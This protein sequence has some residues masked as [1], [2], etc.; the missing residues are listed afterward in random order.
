MFKALV[1]IIG[2]IALIF[3]VSIVEPKAKECDVFHNTLVC[4]KG[5]DTNV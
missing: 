3:V 4:E 2:V 5:V 1:S